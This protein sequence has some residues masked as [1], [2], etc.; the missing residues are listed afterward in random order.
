MIPWVVMAALSAAAHY[1]NPIS[2]PGTP[3]YNPTPRHHFRVSFENDCAFNDDCNYSH[4]SRLEYVRDAAGA[5]HS[6]A[7]SLAQNIYT[8]E[9]RTR[10]AVMNE[11]PYAG[12]LALGGGY[13]RRG[14]YVGCATEFQVGATG[15]ASLA[16][17]AQHLIHALGHMYQWHGWR[18]QVPSELAL[19]LTSRQDY[20]LPWLETETRGGW[21]T[22]GLLYTREAAGT[23]AISGGVG[24]SLRFGRNLPQNMRVNG[25]EAA[26]FAVGLIESDTY[27]RDTTSYFLV[28]QGELDY[29]ARDLTVDGGVFHTFRHK[30][31]SRMPWQFH[32]Q[33]GVGASHHGIDYFA[34][35]L[36]YSRTYRTQDQNSLIGSFSVSWNW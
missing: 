34:G 3:G 27:R 6:F 35:A 11:H 23:L 30:T 15:K 32:G 24:F 20:R 22:D 17:D 18:D 2:A 10:H 7:V 31:C 36:L 12:Y 26:N 4:G 16:E 13:L 28:L 29:V 5:P 9:H 14:K 8:P 1:T 33:F 21:Q 25:A 19:Q